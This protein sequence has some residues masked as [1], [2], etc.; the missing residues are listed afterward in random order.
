[1]GY[2]TVFGGAVGG[3]VP[4]SQCVVSSQKMIAGGSNNG[5]ISSN[6]PTNSAKMQLMLDCTE[7]AQESLNQGLGPVPAGRARRRAGPALRPAPRYR[8]RRRR[9]PPDAGRARHGDGGPHPGGLTI[10]GDACCGHSASSTNSIPARSRSR[11]AGR[12]RRLRRAAALDSGA[13]GR[14]AHDQPA[15]RRPAGGRTVVRRDLQRG[16]AT[17]ARPRLAEDIRGFIGR[18]RPTPT[19]TR[20]SCRTSWSP[21]AP[22]SNRCCV[23][24]ITCSA[25]CSHPAPPPIP[26]GGSTTCA[27]GCG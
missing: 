13:S 4:Q 20:R 5:A 25:A 6:G 1:M 7:K 16:A 11:R 18:R 22:T 10:P 3:D 23:R 14:L 24:W 15:Q 21:A 26:N 17:G 19:P 8:Y 12:V 2:K 27:I 9:Q